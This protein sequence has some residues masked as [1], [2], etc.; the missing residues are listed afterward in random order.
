MGF[1]RT[2]VIYMYVLHMYMY[3]IHAA[4][5]V[6]SSAS[7]DSP[8]HGWTILEQKKHYIV[9]DTYYLVRPTMVASALN[10]YRFIFLALIP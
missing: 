2:Y 6:H 3:C 7:T 8:N 4:F 1:S 5:H 10:M 9:A